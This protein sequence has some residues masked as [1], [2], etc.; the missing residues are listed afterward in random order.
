PLKVDTRDLG[1]RDRKRVLRNGSAVGL[2]GARFLR[3]DGEQEVVSHVE[4]T[5][6]ECPPR[7]TAFSARAAFDGDAAVRPAVATGAKT[8]WFLRHGL[9]EPADDTHPSLFCDEG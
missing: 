4:F 7:L 3:E 9:R 5:A 2:R 6:G 1:P 8:P